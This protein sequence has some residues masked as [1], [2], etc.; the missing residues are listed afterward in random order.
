MRGITAT[1]LMLLLM[2]VGIYAQEQ[3]TTDRTVFEMQRELSE[4]DSAR[5]RLETQ[6]TPLETTVKVVDD[7]IA[8]LKTRK[9]PP[10]V[11]AHLDRAA[12]LLRSKGSRDEIA[13]A[14]Q[15]AADEFERGIRDAIPSATSVTSAARPIVTAVARTIRTPDLPKI[16]RDDFDEPQLSATFTAADLEAIRNA[17][18]TPAFEAAKAVVI[19]AAETR[20]TQQR[21]QL[22]SLTQEIAALKRRATELAKVI[23]ER[24]E[25]QERLDTRLV[26][27]ALPVFGVAML[28]LLFA[29]RVYRSELLQQSIFA[30]GILLELT[31]VF[32]LTVSVLILGLGDRI[33]GE[34]I[35]TLLGGISGYVLGRSVRRQ[36]NDNSRSA[37]TGRAGDFT[38]SA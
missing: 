4:I 13:A 12:Q 34:V 36:E 24:S 19:A 9:R 15:A 29:P 6:V 35:G 5:A 31:T 3:A 21:Q 27:V 37:S 30:S 10:A 28:A 26:N 32:L 16:Q 33:Q 7:I 8:E 20:T 38:E 23:G 14:I 1:T 11:D 25:K 17:L 2:T 18:N 22:A